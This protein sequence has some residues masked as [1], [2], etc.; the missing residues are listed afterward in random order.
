ME[1]TL[2]FYEEVLGFSAVVCEMIRFEGGGVIRHAFFDTGRGELI[3]FMECNDVDGV[4]PDF[5]P[6]INRGLGIQGGMMHFAFEARDEEDLLEKQAELEGKG[7]SVRGV[8]DHGWCKSIYFHDP[9][10]V[11][12]EFCCLKDKLGPEHVAGRD[13]ADWKKLARR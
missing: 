5:D 9:N 10:F 1:R 6:G 2:T 8:V 12:L 7:V 4:P 11:Q 13:S 3:A